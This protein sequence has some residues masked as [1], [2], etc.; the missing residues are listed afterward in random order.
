MRLGSTSVTQATELAGPRASALH[1]A[2]PH[3]VLF[4]GLR[5]LEYILLSRSR[6]QEE[7]LVTLAWQRKRRGGKTKHF[8]RKP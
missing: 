6:L 8:L 2:A 4:N 1:F 3:E 7:I 5:D